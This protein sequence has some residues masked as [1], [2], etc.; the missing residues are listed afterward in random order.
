MAPIPGRHHGQRD[1]GRYGFAPCPPPP[2]KAASAAPSSSAARCPGCSRAA[3]L[4]QI[5]WQAD[6]YER[7]GVELVGRGAGI[8]GA[9]GTARRARRRAAPAP[10][11]SASRCPSASPSTATAASPT[12]GRSRQIL[13][14]W[15]RLQRLL[16]ATID[17][18]QLPPRLEFRAR[19]AGRARRARAVSRRPRRARRHPDRRRRRALQRARPDGAGGAAGLCRL[20]HLARR[21]ERG[22]SRAG[23]ARTASI[24]C[25]PSICRKQQQVITYP[26]AGFNDDLTPGKRRF[27]FIW[28]RVAD[29][30]QA[31]RDE[32]RRERRA[33]RILGA[34]AADPQGPDR[35][36]AR[37][38]AR[39]PAAGDARL[40]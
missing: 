5:G 31:A 32:R 16:R 1:A 13:T 28:Y 10:T 3:F 39:D 8:T 25:S 15:D 23:N 24:R 29:A 7:S 40:R 38:R 14:S 37:R 22:R 20:L 11:I 19:R 2:P 33:A 34:A 4:R 36:D 26:I 17:P 12:S 18:A 6:V 35:G 30:A 21:A 27:N 9:P